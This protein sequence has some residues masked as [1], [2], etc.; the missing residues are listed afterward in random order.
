MPKY[1]RIH[2]C[3]TLLLTATSLIIKVKERS[4]PVV[5]TSETK[6]FKCKHKHG[7]MPQLKPK[8]RVLINKIPQSR[9]AGFR[10][11]PCTVHST[12]LRENISYRWTDDV[13]HHFRGRKRTRNGKWGGVTTP[14]FQKSTFHAVVSSIHS[15][16]PIDGLSHTHIHADADIQHLPQKATTR[17][18]DS[19]QK[20]PLI[21][22]QLVPLH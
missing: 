9:V 19:S 21:P 8:Q 5:H 15:P 16:V 14:A 10:L 20:H 4:S 13:L 3:L 6:T 17:G 18:S 7:L 11:V 1:V 2:A 12:M 22:F